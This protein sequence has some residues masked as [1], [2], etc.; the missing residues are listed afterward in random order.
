MAS[1][2]L[3]HIR[4]VELSDLE[5]EH[6]DVRLLTMY[7]PALGGR[8]D[9]SLFV[10]RGCEA[11]SGVPIV[12]LLHGVH[13]SHWAWFLKGGA[14]RTAGQLINTGR[15]R[16]MVL[17]APSDGLQGDGTAYMRHE[18]GPDYEAW[19]YKDVLECVRNVIP[20]TGVDAPVFIA[21]LSMGGFGALRIG[22][23]H[24]GAFRGIAAHSAIT[25]IDE[26]R[27][28]IYGQLPDVDREECEILS[29]M[30]RNREQLP[31]IRFDCGRE[32]LLIE[33]NRHFHD[34]LQRHNIPH[35]YYEFDGGHSWEYWKTHIGETFLFFEAILQGSTA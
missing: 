2:G 33:G 5:F 17:A 19:I 26:M 7:S 32:D 8:G 4:T 29:W 18:N 12:L 35:E 15:M 23:R 11:A 13:G 14:H 9:V 16:P 1:N 28:F 21:G 25:H 20:C 10:P 31:P 30:E 24:A 27:K 3:D 22:A 34:G 6:D